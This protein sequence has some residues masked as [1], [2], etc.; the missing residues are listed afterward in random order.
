MKDYETVD[1]DISYEEYF[2][3]NEKARKKNML[4]DDFINDILI[5]ALKDEKFIEK[6]AK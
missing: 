5:K 3:L 4:L 6:I 1:I 2:L